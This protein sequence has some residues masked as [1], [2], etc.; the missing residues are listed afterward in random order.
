MFYD[1]YFNDVVELFLSN[2]KKNYYFITYES[3]KYSHI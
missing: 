2:E 3:I 1:F